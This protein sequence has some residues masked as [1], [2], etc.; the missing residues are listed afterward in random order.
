MKVSRCLCV[1]S[2]VDNYGGYCIS[3]LKYPSR[4]ARLWGGEVQAIGTHVLIVGAI[5]ED[6]FISMP[7]V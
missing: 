1:I 2:A 7:F 4:V 3:S 5:A 6:V